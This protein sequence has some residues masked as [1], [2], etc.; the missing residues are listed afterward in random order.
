M[1]SF[2][3]KRLLL[4]LKKVAKVDKNG[5]RLIEMHPFLSKIE[6]FYENVVYTQSYII[7]RNFGIQRCHKS[8]IFKAKHLIT[9]YNSY[10][11]NLGCG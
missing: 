1:P 3:C 5:L 9:K 2:L 11:S 7:Q 8:L 6:D 4:G 10:S